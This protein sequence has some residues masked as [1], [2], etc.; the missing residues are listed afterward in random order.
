MGD[1][2]PCC[3]GEDDSYLSASSIDG[4]RTWTPFASY[5]NGHPTELVYGN[6]AVSSSNPSN[7]VWLPT[8]NGAP[9][10]TTDGGATWTPVRLPGTED[11]DE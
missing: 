6:I 3:R 1:Q 7:I 2:R 10:F 11:Q 9:H 4:G 5:G 8:F